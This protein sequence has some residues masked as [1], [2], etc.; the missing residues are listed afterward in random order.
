MAYD[1][2]YFVT[3]EKVSGL[4]SGI[5]LFFASLNSTWRLAIGSY[6]TW[7]TKGAPLF[8]VICLENPV[9]A[10]DISLITD[11][12]SLALAILIG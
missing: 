9:A 6:L 3:L 5:F 4:N 2:H 12:F 7:C 8:T 1:T 10:V 11:T